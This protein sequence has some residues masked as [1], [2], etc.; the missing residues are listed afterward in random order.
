LSPT[1]SAWWT[2]SSI[3]ATTTP[4]TSPQLPKD[5]LLVAIR[6]ARSEAGRDELEDQVAGPGLGL[7]GNRADLVA[8]CGHPHRA[9]CADPGTV[10][11]RRR[12]LGI[13]RVDGLLTSWGIV[14]VHIVPLV[15]WTL[16]MSEHGPP[17]WRRCDVGDAKEAGSAPRACRWLPVIL[18]GV[19]LHARD[20]A[21]TSEGAGSA[22]SVDGGPRADAGRAR[23][24]VSRSS[25][26]IDV[27][28]SSGRCRTDAAWC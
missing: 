5:L 17:G 14:V 4:K 15:G 13:P 9:T 3:M 23:L 24:P 16:P 27:L 11:T 28:T 18:A 21:G 1:T 8:L 19:A 26:S 7:E 2:S 10:P 6:L 20:G 22:W 25:S 12:S